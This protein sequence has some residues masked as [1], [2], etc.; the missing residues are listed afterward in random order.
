M[1]YYAIYKSLPTI[2]G[3]GGAINGG[4]GLLPGTNQS[5]IGITPFIREND[6]NFA[7]ASLKPDNAAN[8][9]F[10]DIKCFVH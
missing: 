4:I 8:F 2:G 6:I 5:P 10:D 3:F 9:F 7:A 1:D